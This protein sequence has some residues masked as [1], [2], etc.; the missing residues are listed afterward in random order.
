MSNSPL[1]RSQ[2]IDLPVGRFHYQSLGAERND[3]P[4]W[5]CSTVSQA[6]H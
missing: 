6:L 5:C 4:V 3:L 1:V 2:T